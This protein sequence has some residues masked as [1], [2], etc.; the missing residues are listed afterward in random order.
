[1]KRR[2]F[3][4]AQGLQGPQGLPRPR[5]LRRRGLA[6]PQYSQPPCSGLP[7]LSPPGAVNVSVFGELSSQLCLA[8]IFP[9]ENRDN[10]AFLATP[11]SGQI[12]NQPYLPCDGRGSMTATFICQL[13]FLELL[14]GTRHCAKC[15][16]VILL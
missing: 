3:P 16:T 10:D 2:Q 8:S 1:M 13:I 4:P 9:S 14:K 12:D 7:V 15:F 11:P 5:H 6:T